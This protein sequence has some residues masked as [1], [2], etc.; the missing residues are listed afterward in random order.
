MDYDEATKI[1]QVHKHAT[2]EEIKKAWRAKVRE[3][4]PDHGGSSEK[5]KLVQEA[6]QYLTEEDAVLTK[7]EAEIFQTLF[8][9]LFGVQMDKKLER[10]VQKLEEQAKREEQEP[11][12]RIRKAKQTSKSES[13]RIRKKKN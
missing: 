9:D 7:M 11:P 1:L 4:H 2:K 3:V 5:F 12:I 13:S 10:V 6:Y 8:S